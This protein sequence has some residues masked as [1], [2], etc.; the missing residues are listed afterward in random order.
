MIHHGRPRRADRAQFLDQVVAL[1]LLEDDPSAEVGK[2]VADQL[3]RFGE[4]VRAA[5]QGHRNALR[6]VGGG[7]DLERRRTR[8]EPGEHLRPRPPVAL[9]VRPDHPPLEPEGGIPHPVPAHRVAHREL[10]G[11]IRRIGCRVQ[12]PPPPPE[13][14]RSPASES[15]PVASA[16]TQHRTTLP[17]RPPTLSWSVGHSR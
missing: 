3:D 11:G 17:R 14:R 7:A 16:W 9:E 4:P 10:V 2:L 5:L 13:P 1:A 12:P 8:F 6:D 15:V